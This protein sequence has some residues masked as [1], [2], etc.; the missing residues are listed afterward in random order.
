MVLTPFLTFQLTSGK[1]YLTF[2]ALV[3][4]KT[5]R[6]KYTG[7]CLYVDFWLY[8]LVNISFFYVFY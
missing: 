3:L 1:H 7:F 6:L 4:L 2:F 8:I 5:L